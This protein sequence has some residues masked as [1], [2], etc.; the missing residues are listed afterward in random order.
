[1]ELLRIDH[2]KMASI[3]SRTIFYRLCAGTLKY[4][5]TAAPKRAD[6]YKLRSSCGPGAQHPHCGWIL[7]TTVSCNT[8]LEHRRPRPVHCIL[9]VDHEAVIWRQIRV[10]EA[11]LFKPSGSY[12]SPLDVSTV[13]IS[14][15]YH[16]H[17][18]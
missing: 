10:R 15:L 4:S 9:I 5:I 7:L 12:T 11:T 18:Y 16:G 1:M 14:R 3:F 13:N 17:L 8:T 2:L 6:P